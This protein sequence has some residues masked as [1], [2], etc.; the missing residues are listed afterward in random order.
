MIVLHKVYAAGEEMWVS[1]AAPANPGWKKREF[2][3]LDPVDVFPIHPCI[4]VVSFVRLFMSR[5]PSRSGL[6]DTITTF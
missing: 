1:M 5:L 4:H 6:Y 3:F 2:V